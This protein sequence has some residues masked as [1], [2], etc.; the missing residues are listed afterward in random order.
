MRGLAELGCCP[1]ARRIGYPWTPRLP[2]VRGI[3]GADPFAAR[4][5]RPQDGEKPGLERAAWRSTPRGGF[6]AAA[7]VMRF[8]FGL[9]IRAHTHGRPHK[10]RERPLLA[11]GLMQIPDVVS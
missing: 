7:R 2:H 11:S 4:L 6:A 10:R 1:V 9:Q 8:L 3:S 5:R